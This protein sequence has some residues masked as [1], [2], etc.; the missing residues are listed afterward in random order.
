MTR[1]YDAQL[2][3]LALATAARLQIPLRQGV[4]MCLA[5]PCFETPADIR[6]L[7]TIGAD[8][9]GMS[10]VPEAVVARHGGMRVLGIST[11][12][13]MA[14]DDID[15]EAETTHQE[16]LETGKLVVPRLTALLQ[17]I[18]ADLPAPE[19]GRSLKKPHGYHRQADQVTMR[20]GS[21]PRALVAL[22]YLRVP[23]KRGRATPGGL[24]PGTRSRAEQDLSG[25]QHRCLPAG[26]DRASFTSSATTWPPRCS[27]W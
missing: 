12:S 5:G 21:T 24:Q 15:S 9:V 25:A 4:Y 10:T 20:P 14:I 23:C 18:L 17:A 1:V 2:R 19:T 3:A 13:N 22:W 8:A 7:R 27:L 6:F 26:D 11:I 16:V